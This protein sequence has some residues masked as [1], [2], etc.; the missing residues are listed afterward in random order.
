MLACKLYISNA[1]LFTQNSNPVVMCLELI[2]AG[3]VQGGGGGVG[4]GCPKVK[5]RSQGTV[6][7]DSLI[8]K[9]LERNM[10]SNV[11]ILVFWAIIEQL[12]R[13]FQHFFF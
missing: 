6:K 8:K 11:N 5:I 10:K 1:S 3:E 4:G 7:K 9:F 13:N 2:L 12:F